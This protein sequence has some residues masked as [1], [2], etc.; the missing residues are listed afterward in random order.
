MLNKR[1]Q[2]QAE[3]LSQYTRSSPGCCQGSQNPGCCDILL[4]PF[5]AGTETPHTIVKGWKARIPWKFWRGHSHQGRKGT[6]TA[7]A[8]RNSRYSH[9]PGIIQILPEHCNSWAVS[10]AN[11]SRRWKKK[12]WDEWELQSREMGTKRKSSRALWWLQ[13]L[14]DRPE[15]IWIQKIHLEWQEVQG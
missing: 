6:T 3:V 1:G 15:S 4:C 14:R 11:G 7:P 5:A 8:A 12:N 10:K 9:L 2:N 13:I